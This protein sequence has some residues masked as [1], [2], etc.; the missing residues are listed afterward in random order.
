[1]LARVADP[2]SGKICQELGFSVGY[3]GDPGAPDQISHHDSHRVHSM[4][5]GPLAP[6]HSE[7]LLHL[8]DQRITT[9]THIYGQVV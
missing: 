1:M 4:Q 2:V 7:F 3:H 6:P 8:F 9:P 5:A